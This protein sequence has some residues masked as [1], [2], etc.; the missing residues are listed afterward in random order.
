MPAARLLSTP[1]I[2]LGDERVEIPQGKTS[3]LLY[4]LAYQHDWVNREDILYLFW[5]DT[6]ELKARNNLRQLLSAIRKL[7]FVGSLE[8][9]NHRLRW[10]VPSDTQ[11]FKEAFVEENWSKA[12]TCYQGPLLYGFRN[13]GLPEFESWLELERANLFSQYRSAVFKLS[14]HLER[15]GRYAQAAQC[16]GRLHQFEP[17]DEHVLQYYMRQLALAERQSEALSAFERFCKTLAL[18]L[19]AEPETATQALVAKIRSGESLIQGN[20]L[21]NY[22]EPSKRVQRSLPTPPT[23]FVGREAELGQLTGLLRDPT[24]RLLSLVAAGGMGKT[25]LATELAGRLEPEFK[26]GV[27]F[28]PFEAISSPEL[29]VTAIAEALTFTFFGQQDPKDQLFEYLT[30]KEML[31]VADNLEHLV[32]ESGFFSEL[33]EA[34]PELSILATSRESLLLQAEWVYDVS[35]MDSEAAASQENDAVNLFV[36][37]AKKAKSGFVLDEQNRDAVTAICQQVGGMPLAIELAASWL[38]VLT[39]GDIARELAEGMD[40][41]EGQSRDAPERHR[42]IRAVFEQSWHRLS[43]REQEVLAKLS[44]FRGG[45]TKDAAESVTG[46]GLPILISLVNKSFLRVL[47]GGRFDRHPLVYEFCLEKLA[48]LD[49]AQGVHERHAEYFLEFAKAASPELRGREQ[50]RWFRRIEE[51]HDNSLAVL[52]W[53]LKQEKFEMGLQLAIGM[54]W[55][56]HVRGYYQI[57]LSWLK[58]FL[59]VTPSKE[60]LNLKIYAHS[61]V[62]RFLTT[63]GDYFEAEKFHRVSLTLARRLKDKQGIADSLINIAGI[64]YSQG[65]YVEAKKLSEE[66]RDMYQELGAERGL[67]LSL[68]RLGHIAHN[69]G[70]FNEAKKLHEKSLALCKKFG[71]PRGIADSFSYLGLI[72]DYQNNWAEA[73]MHFEKS[74]SLYKE[75]GDHLGRAT[76]IGGLGSVARYQGEYDK[77]KKYFGESLEIRKE[78]GER[79]GVAISLFNLGDVALNQGHVREAKKLLKESLKLFKELGDQAGIAFTLTI[80]AVTFRRADLLELSVKIFAACQ[81]FCDRIGLLLHPEIES[82]MRQ[83]LESNQKGLGDKRFNVLWQEGKQLSVNEA[84]EL[85]LTSS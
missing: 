84:I 57:G 50:A 48:G 79:R 51:E 65:N 33:L 42:S 66:C 77:A 13:P 27:C 1:G 78:F 30:H 62:G 29:L 6:E 39:S 17:F 61:F 24:C 81:A 8:T 47:P 73:Q 12:A 59:I 64:H 82:K 43:A 55:F 7:P 44:V 9:T 28:V 4:Y 20:H 71:D 74:L 11:A 52:E 67:A 60:H 72:A 75:L 53:T 54:A 15:E 10:T 41:L 76:V 25:R 83:S 80:Y 19:D 70:N 85:A 38:R 2:F 26:D 68:R 31:L 37:T 49:D 18:E 40:I 5:S 58:K 45:F 23:P 35:G 63:S 56:W 46:A 16:L 14:E 21:H 3:A 34:A 32:K 36:Q 69:Q 22:S